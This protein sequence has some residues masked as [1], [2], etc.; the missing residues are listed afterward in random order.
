MACNGRVVNIEKED[1]K[2]KAYILHSPWCIN[3]AELWICKNGIISYALSSYS[4]GKISLRN[5]LNM[6]Y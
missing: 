2:K 6:E 5:V 3:S 1:G 4:Q